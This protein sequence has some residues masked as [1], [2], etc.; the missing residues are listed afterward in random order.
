MMENVLY[1]FSICNQLSSNCFDLI[2]SFSTIN[3]VFVDGE[4]FVQEG[5]YLS[6]N[7][8][9]QLTVKQKMGKYEVCKKYLK[10]KLKL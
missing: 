9:S 5:A 6:A 10:S 7:D 2:F 4:M 3:E 1:N 8:P